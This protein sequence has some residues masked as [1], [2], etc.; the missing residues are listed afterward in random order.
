MSEAKPR[1]SREVRELLA[2][3]VSDPKSQLLTIPT[4]DSA[5]ALRKLER[6]L[7]AR[8]N[9]ES[10][11]DRLL[12]ERYREEVAELL[13]RAACEI[14]REVPVEQSH[15]VWGSEP[16]DLGQ[17]EHRAVRLQ[18]SGRS[19][20]DELDLLVG[21]CT[22]RERISAYGLARSCNSLLPTNVRRVLVGLCL[23]RDGRES[24]AKRQLESVLAN[25][26]SASEVSL[27][28]M[29]LAHLEHLR[30]D[31]PASRRLYREA[32]KEGDASPSAYCEWFT[33]SLR[34]G[35]SDQ[36]IEAAAQ[37]EDHASPSNSF[38]SESMA[39]LRSEV[40]AGRWTLTASGE[41]LARRIERTLPPT[42]KEIV[43]VVTKTTA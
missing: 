13:Y 3:A 17:V 12:V 20:C 9:F 15:I 43:D 40:R 5:R 14:L 42:A 1:I 34:L 21:H 18:L 24:E 26:P 8:P 30:G 41:R 31:F 36:T 16:V 33:S 19:G 29:N 35:D 23:I 38:L 6:P 7:E 11:L 27:S 10:S 2:E 4:I 32:C 28:L 37:L 22:N 25:T 39:L